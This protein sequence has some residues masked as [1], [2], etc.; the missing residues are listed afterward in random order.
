MF[1][2]F[3]LLA[4]FISHAAAFSAVSRMISSNAAVRRRPLVVPPCQ[5]TASIAALDDGN[6]RRYLLNN[7]NDA[8]PVLID[9]C[10]QW[11]GPCKLIEPILQKCTEKWHG[12]VTIFK[13]DVGDDKNTANVK[14]ELVLQDVLPRSLPSLILFHNGKALAKHNGVLT[15]EQL[16]DFLRQNLPVASSNSNKVLKKMQ[17]SSMA[18]TTT[19]QR[20]AGFVSFANQGDDYMLSDLSV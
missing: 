14:L 16:D 19:P 7:D 6:Y 10:A 18:K 8:T 3:S 12:R 20:A 2:S 9:A 5:A 1:R 17:Q 11:C 13:L 15:E 4:F